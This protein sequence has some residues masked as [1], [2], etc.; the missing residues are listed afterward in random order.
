MPESLVIITKRLAAAIVIV[1]VLVGAVFGLEKLSGTNPAHVYLGAGASSA[2]VAREKR[3]LGLDKPLLVQFWHYLLGV[4]QGN[5]GTSY[6]TRDPVAQDLLRY[7]PATLELAAYAL[8]LALALGT[9]LGL[10]S[11]AGRRGSGVLKALMVSGASAPIFLLALGGILV[12]YSKLGWLPATGQSS[13]ANPPSGPT[14]FLTIDAALHGDWGVLFDAWRHLVLPASCLAIVPAV[15]IGRVLRG[16]LVA[17]LREDYVRTARAKGLREP[18]VLV[19]HA[20]RNSVGPAL[21]MAGL[22]AGLLLAGDVVVEEIF[23]WPGVGNY[24]AQALPVG[25]F[26]AISAV[27]IVFGVGYVAINALV[28][29]MQKLADPRVRA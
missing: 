25:D 1:V 11:A 6:R 27:T 3:A 8:L 17:V 10:M 12:F 22:Q 23:A 21:S 2:Q 19:R 26:P 7:L 13:Y 28:D 20:L 16:S 14:G 4:A 18:A 29:L 9:L 5:F 24:V 15:S